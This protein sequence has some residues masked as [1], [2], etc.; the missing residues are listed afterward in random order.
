MKTALELLCGLVLFLYGME[1]MGDSLKKSA[2]SSLKTILGKLTSSPIKGFLLGLVVTAI[3]QSSSATTV[4][5][6]GFVTSGTMT[7]VQATGV[8]IGANVGTTVTAWITG[9]SGL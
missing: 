4:M 9:L 2:G 7:L 6:V 5:V 8:I 3:I 1:L